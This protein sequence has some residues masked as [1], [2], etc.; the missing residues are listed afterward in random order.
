M[1]IDQIT[2]GVYDRGGVLRDGQIALNL[3]GHDEY[4]IPNH[5]LAQAIRPQTVIPSRQPAMAGAAQGRGGDTYNTYATFR[6]EKAF[7]DEQRTQS[8]L[9]V[10]RGRGQL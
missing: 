3:S 2:G 8:R 7:Y 10:A 4:V 6:D 9:R 1:R 5:I